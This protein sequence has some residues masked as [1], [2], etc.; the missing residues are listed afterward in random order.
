MTSTVRLWPNV[1]TEPYSGAATWISPPFRL[2]YTMLF[3]SSASPA[4]QLVDG[5][6]MSTWEADSVTL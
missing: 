4:F 6:H 2:H 3:G 5:R 1:S